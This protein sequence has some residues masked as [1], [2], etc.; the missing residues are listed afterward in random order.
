MSEENVKRK[1]KNDKKKMSMKKKILIGISAF[2][3]VILISLLGGYIYFRNTFYQATNPPVESG[4]DDVDY[5]EVEGITNVLLIGT[6]G[7]TL[8]EKSRSD[9]MIIA[10]IDKNN[11]NVKLVSIMRDTLVNI[12]GHGEQK[13]NAAYAFG[14][15][16]LLMQTISQNFGIKL[17]KYVA[18]N[19][20][21]FESIIDEIGGL[22]LEVKDYE[23][24]EIN[25]FMGEAT[26]GQ[27]SESITKAG[28]QTLDGQQA[29]SYARI[30]K[31]G[32]GAYERDA[33]Q[34]EVLFKLAEKLKDTNPIKWP[35]LATALSGQVK[36]NID[37]PEALNLA[38]TI[39]KMPVLDLKEM[40]IPQN[41]ISWGGLYKNKGWV[42]LCDKEQNG[43]LLNEFLFENKIPE[44]T[45]FDTKSWRAKLTQLK[46]EEKK[47]NKDNNI[48][49][50]DHVTDEDKD[51]PIDELPPPVKPEEPQV[52]KKN[53]NDYIK[54]GDNVE[55][56]KGKL[57]NAGF[58]VSV[59]GSGTIVES[60]SPSGEQEVG[61][62]IT[63]KTKA[64]EQV[65]KNVNDYINIGD[66]IETATAKLQA[67]GFKVAVSGSGT[68][69]G[70]FSP[71]GM[72]AVG[73]TI[74][75]VAKEVEPEVPG[76]ANPEETNL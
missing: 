1:S 43:K 31:V 15:V 29:L 50:D 73:T 34:R 39:Y 3:G 23:I 54:A 35:G 69:V 33:R 30:R 27:T 46:D 18:V 11:N 2:L 6:D 28:V 9:S 16:E 17:D 57:Q 58:K 7:R 49:P 67:A 22:E 64:P 74:K 20:W 62:T 68:V 41:E 5:R 48:N 21:G 71:N 36:T 56:A 70:S 26:G 51:K 12:P 45:T 53:V 61:T 65:K 63:I 25:K 14:G 47:Y 76:D 59:S 55:T 10:S 42:L 37:I 60:F 4:N 44:P 38:Y 72:Q 40:Q 24:N 19:F 32:N 52:Q 66:N 13:I 75:I 8:D